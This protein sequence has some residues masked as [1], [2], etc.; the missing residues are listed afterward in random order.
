MALLSPA[1][2][3]KSENEV[4]L[5]RLI[6]QQQE[7]QAQPVLPIG[8]LVALHGC[9]VCA[10]FSSHTASRWIVENMSIARHMISEKLGQ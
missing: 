2:P 3:E 8:F 9:V 7:G 6:A 4:E 1:Y 5:T 10:R